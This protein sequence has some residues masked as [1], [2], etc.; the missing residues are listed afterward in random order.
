MI[1]SGNESL[2]FA[3]N[4]SILWVKLRLEGPFSKKMLFSGVFERLFFL[5]LRNSMLCNI[6]GCLKKVLLNFRGEYQDF[7]IF[8][9]DNLV[10]KVQKQRFYQVVFERSEILR[11]QEEKALLE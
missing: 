8:P 2:E 6:S 11:K 9:F 1:V 10:E 5:A 7:L 3:S 4:S